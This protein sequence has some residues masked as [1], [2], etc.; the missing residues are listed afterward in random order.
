MGHRSYLDVGT[1]CLSGFLSLTVKKEKNSSQAA[2]NIQATDMGGF[3]TY[4]RK[5]FDQVSHVITSSF[6]VNR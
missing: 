6:N 4:H 3:L 2:V 5:K 1:D